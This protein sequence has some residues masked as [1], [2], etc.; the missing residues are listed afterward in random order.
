[1][2][3]GALLKKFRKDKGLSQA[4]LGRR[5][6]TSQ[7][8]I[9]RLENGERPVTLRWARK[10]APIL[11]VKEADLEPVEGGGE[12]PIVG[13]VGAGETVVYFHDDDPENTTEAPP[14]LHEGAALRVRG[15]SMAP[16]YFDGE[17]IFYSDTKGLDP[18]NCIRKD[19]VVRLAD[20]R[21]LLKRVE[22]GTEK[23][24]YTLRS[25]NPSGPTLANQ[26]VEWMAPVIWRG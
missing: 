19:C 17:I 5:V 26:R 18:R 10:I 4:E 15:H 8:Q 23:G 21:V 11:D 1:M 13:Y 16:R 2:A 22:R 6:G 24:T 9:A 12:V 7:Q 14:G 20:G 3:D 25:Y